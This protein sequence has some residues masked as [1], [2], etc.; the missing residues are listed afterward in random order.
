MP[1]LITLKRIRK[2]KFI[3]MVISK[4]D[5]ELIRKFEQIKKKGLYVQS[6]QMQKVYNTVFETNM[7]ATS[8]GTCI[9]GR[10]N[11]LVDALNKLEKE[12][13]EEDAKLAEQENKVAES[14]DVT[15]NKVPETQDVTQEK[16]ITEEPENADKPKSHKA[17]GRKEK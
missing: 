11:K 10:I 17:K 5:R 4:E 2:I 7:A 13:M 1:T 9:R 3:F 8:C 6:A 12:E 16:E 14:E 15:N